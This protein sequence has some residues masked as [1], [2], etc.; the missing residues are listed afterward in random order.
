MTVEDHLGEVHHAHIR[1]VH[2]AAQ[3]DV[4][5][6]TGRLHVLRL[7]TARAARGALAAGASKE[8]IGLEIGTQDYQVIDSLLE[9]PDA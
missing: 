7:A 2:A 5:A 8:Q 3:E 6:D 1:E 4:Q 9:Y